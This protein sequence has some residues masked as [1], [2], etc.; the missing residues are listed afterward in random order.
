MEIEK[1]NFFFFIRF[2]IFQKLIRTFKLRLLNQKLFSLEKMKN[3]LLI[4]I[5]F[6]MFS[7]Y[8]K[9]MLYVFSPYCFVSM[10]IGYE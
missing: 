6:A 2:D 8:D 4:P 9:H 3:S 7:F 1:N 5:F 10:F